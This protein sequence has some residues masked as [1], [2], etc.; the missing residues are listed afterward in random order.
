[1][2][3]WWALVLLPALVRG[4]FRP[5]FNGRDL[6]GWVHEGPHP[7]SSVVSGELRISGLAQAGNWVHTAGEYED[8]RLRFEYNLKQ[9]AEAAVVVRAPRSQRPQMAGL[10]VVLAHDFHKETT[11]YTT[12]ALMGVRAPKATLAASFEKWHAVEISARGNALR[13][14]IDGEVVQDLSLRDVPELRHRLKRGVIGFPDMGHG[15]ALRGLAIE[16][17]G[18]PTKIVD[19]VSNNSLAGWGKR[20]DS[21]EWRLAGDVVEGMNGHSILYAPGEWK[22]FEFT[23]VVRTHLRVNAGVFLRG[24][25]EGANRGFEVQVYS[26][27][28][29]VYPTGSVYGRQRA[30]ISADLEEQWFLLQVR[31]EGARCTVWV[32]GEQT[33]DFEGLPEELRQAGRIGL[34]IHSDEGRVEFRDVRARAI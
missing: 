29:A 23:A 21:G 7:S 20:G 27:V 17:L 16:E 9:W 3:Y 18:A 34:Q 2:R 4:E 19:L 11:P 15:Y 6:S 25:P 13:V 8:F 5:L 24:W 33:A 30:R 14:T 10:T 28:D 31:V 12:G 22:D 26:P 32:N 1:M